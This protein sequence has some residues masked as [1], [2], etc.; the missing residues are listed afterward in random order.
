V[1]EKIS[2]IFLLSLILSLV[3]CSIEEDLS[4]EHTMESSYKRV[5]AEI[6]KLDALSPTAG[7]STASLDWNFSFFSKIYATAFEEGGVDNWSVTTNLS[8]HDPQETGPAISVK[9]YFGKQFNSELA[10]PNGSA[11]NAFGRIKSALGIFCAVGSLL[12]TDADGYPS[13]GDHPITFTLAVLQ[14]LED[15]DG[16]DVSFEKNEAGDYEMQDQTITL[17]VTNATDTTVYDKKL[18][19]DMGA[20]EMTFYMRYNDNV[21]NIVSTE[22]NLSGDNAGHEYR[23][24]VQHDIAGD[25]LRAEYISAPGT[26]DNDYLYFYRLHMTSAEA[27]V[28]AFK[29]TS[30]TTEN[31]TYSAAGT[32]EDSTTTSALSVSISSEKNATVGGSSYVDL[33][34]CIDRMDGSIDADDA[35]ACGTNLEDASQ[36]SSHVRALVAN[37]I[38]S[39]ALAGWVEDISEAND[40]LNFDTVAE[41]FSEEPN[42]PE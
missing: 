19:V 13:N 18:T 1:K 17:N 21:I 34:A 39:K 12:E 8:L 42:K 7:A 37:F 9:D 24:V 15:D 32:I 27:R 14:D 5:T 11:I 4:T 30:V 6:G 35:L 20:K 29:G 40:N 25:L 26:S 10:R 33:N 41:M 3:G 22:K 38:S 36:Q 31:I 2:L 16:C 28:L 23:T